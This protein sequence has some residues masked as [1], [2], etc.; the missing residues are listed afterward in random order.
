MSD[1]QA[2][3]LTRSQHTLLQKQQE[4]AGLQALREASAGL[5]EKVEKLSEMSNIMAD[6]GE[7]E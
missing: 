2:Q 6:G 7:G 3:Q 4:H 1:Q 5:L